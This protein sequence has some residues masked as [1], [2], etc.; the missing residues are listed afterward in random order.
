M[1][2]PLDIPPAPDEYAS[3]YARYV[4]LAA[5][6][7]DLPG[8]LARQP[9]E[10]RDLCEGLDEEGA[11]FRYAPGKWSVKEVLEHLTDTERVY[12]YRALRVARGDATPLAGFDENAF[13]GAA[14]SDRRPLVELLD[15]FEVVR[16]A[17][18]A[19]FRGLPE[20]AWERRGVAN[21]A[22]VSTRS[23]AFVA[24]G[25]VQHHLGL[26]RERYG[27]GPGNTPGGAG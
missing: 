11:L 1:T 26:F 24:A 14:A 8:L 22:P 3:Y 5:A 23:L 21:G 15:D 9:A 17:T 6:G 25:H 7:G 20:E 18:L 4:E 2:H 19:L 13:V 16:G 12:A 10:L 27:L